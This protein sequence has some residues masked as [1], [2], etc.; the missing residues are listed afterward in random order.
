MAWDDDVTQ[1]RIAGFEVLHDSSTW[2]F[3][4]ITY[5]ETFVFRDSFTSG[6]IGLRPNEFTETL[7]VIGDNWHQRA[8]AIRNALTKSGSFKYVHPYFKAYIVKL[9]GTAKIDTSAQLLGRAKITVTMKEDE[10]TTFPV[11]AIPPEVSKAADY[12]TSVAERDFE[13]K[14]DLLGLFDD[15]VNNISNAIDTSTKELGD[16]NNAVGARLN[17]VSNLAESIKKFQRQIDNFI[18]L[19]SAIAATLINLFNAVMEIPSLVTLADSTLSPFRNIRASALVR[20]DEIRRN[21]TEVPKGPADVVEGIV[22]G[23][24]TKDLTRDDTDAG[25]YG[26][27]PPSLVL[28]DASNAVSV[29]ETDKSRIPTVDPIPERVQE[30]QAMVAVDN[31]IKRA[32]VIGLCRNVTQ[33]WWQTVSQ[34]AAVT[35]TILAQRDA[36]LDDPDTPD[37]VG[38]SITDLTSLA[39]QHLESEAANPSNVIKYTTAEDDN[40]MLIAWKLFGDPGQEARVLERVDHTDPGGIPSGT[41]LEIFGG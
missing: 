32:G 2:S 26:V 21:V 13:E 30:L 24:T 40:A 25:E 11:G 28:M 14:F 34:I 10:P 27:E 19:P 20:R 6:D 18:H 38:E 7:Y 17:V 16:I 31:L 41:T 23:K 33:V 15:I 4:R 39:I 3:G 22:V 29:I 37:D 9:V 8:M 35:E 36:I 1:C 12:A 5:H